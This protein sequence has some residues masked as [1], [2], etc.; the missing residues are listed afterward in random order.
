MIEGVEELRAKLQA[1][2]FSDLDLPE[3]AQIGTP[4]PRPVKSARR[5]GPKLAIGRDGEG[6]R[7]QEVTGAGAH[8]PV[9]TGSL[10]RN[11]CVGIANAIRVRVR[12]AGGGVAQISCANRNGRSGLSRNDGIELPA[13]RQLA[14]RAAL[15]EPFTSLAER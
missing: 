10:V 14:G 2:A 7:V 1:L 3:E 13:T 11:S 4:Q 12:A 9:G 8:V 15:V 6:R 5:A